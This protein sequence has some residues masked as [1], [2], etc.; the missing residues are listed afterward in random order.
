MDHVEVE[1]VRTFVQAHRYNIGDTI[2]L[3]NS[4]E[5]S[6][7]RRD[8]GQAP[9]GV[10]HVLIIARNEVA[11][12]VEYTAIEEDDEEEKKKKRGSKKTNFF[13]AKGKSTQGAWKVFAM[14]FQHK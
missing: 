12:Q 14:H 7:E 8:L 9:N 11:S 6:H 4:H 2:Y 5:W 1:M 3:L 10:L 13:K